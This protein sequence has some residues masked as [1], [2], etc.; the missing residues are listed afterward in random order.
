[1]NVYF[2]LMKM[3]MTN[4]YSKL[5]KELNMGNDSKRKIKNILCNI[6]YFSFIEQAAHL[7]NDADVPCLFVFSM[8]LFS[9]HRAYHRNERIIA[10][11]I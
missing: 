6:L 1:M 4:F 9:E 2:I 7:G 11:N 3:N 10:P 8:K 5:K